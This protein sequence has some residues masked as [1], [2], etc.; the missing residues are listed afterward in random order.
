MTAIVSTAIGTGTWTILYL[1]HDLCP[2][3]KS[4]FLNFDRDSYQDMF[5]FRYKRVGGLCQADRRMRNILDDTTKI[6]EMLMS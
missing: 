2:E 5:L 3:L 6:G 4:K 1:C